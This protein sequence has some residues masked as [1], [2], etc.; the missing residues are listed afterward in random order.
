[1][2]KFVIEDERDLGSQFVVYVEY[3]SGSILCQYFADDKADALNWIK[4]MKGINK[5]TRIEDK[6]SEQITAKK[7]KK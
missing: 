3:K 5:F 7:K 6:T 2:P 4:Q 1:M